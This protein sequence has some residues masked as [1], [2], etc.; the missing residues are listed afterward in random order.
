MTSAA[1]GEGGRAKLALYSRQQFLVYG[2]QLFVAVTHTQRWTGAPKKKANRIER[3]TAAGI[4]FNV[5]A[6]ERERLRDREG[7][8]EA[9]SG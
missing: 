4:E 8:R 5:P 9:E 3:V 1:G 6:T 2:L 7:G